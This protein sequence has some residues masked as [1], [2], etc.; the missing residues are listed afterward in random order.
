MVTLT[1]DQTNPVAIPTRANITRALKWLVQ[2]AKP[3]DQL[4]LHFSGHGGQTEDMD[5]DEEDGLDEVIYP[6][7]FKSNGHITDDV[8]SPSFIYG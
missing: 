6:V 2:D 5:G 3:N 4:F 8:H 1:D 7:D